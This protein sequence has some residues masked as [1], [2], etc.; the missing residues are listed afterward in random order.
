[1]NLHTAF[2][3][4]FVSKLFTY[5]QLLL[6]KYFIYKDLLLRLLA[7]H[8]T[9]SKQSRWW[10]I[11]E[12]K[13]LTE[14]QKGRETSFN[15]QPTWHRDPMFKGPMNWG[16]TII[17]K[18]LYTIPFNKSSLSLSASILFPETPWLILLNGKH[19][20]LFVNR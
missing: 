16:V 18:W 15:C 10:K 2:L 11:R 6:T 17:L 1:M 12:W 7:W 5:S 19:F 20:P 13:R 4:C 8:L 3:H 14:N 9:N